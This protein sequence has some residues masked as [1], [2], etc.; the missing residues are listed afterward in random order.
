MQRAQELGLQEPQDQR[1]SGNGKSL[2]ALA[3]VSE[4]KSLRKLNILFFL[5]KKLQTN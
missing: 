2:L 3:W 1:L 5:K 4:S